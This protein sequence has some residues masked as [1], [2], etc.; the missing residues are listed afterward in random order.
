MNKKFFT[1]NIM[2]FVKVSFT[3]AHAIINLIDNIESAIDNKK[4]VC[5]VLIDL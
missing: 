4:F 1:V 5:A 2:D 3:T